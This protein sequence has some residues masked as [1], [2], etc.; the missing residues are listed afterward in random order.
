MIKSVDQTGFDFQYHVNTA[1]DLEALIFNLAARSYNCRDECSR[2]SS[3]VIPSR[4][5]GISLTVS[6]VEA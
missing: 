6:I 4:F 5:G 1:N 2:R 3:P